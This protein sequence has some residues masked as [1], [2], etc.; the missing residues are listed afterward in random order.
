[1]KN[2]TLAVL[3]LLGALTSVAQ[4]THLS[5]EVVRTFEEPIG[6]TDLTGFSTFR[7][8]VHFESEDDFLSSIYGYGLDTEKP[9]AYSPDEED[10]AIVTDCECFNSEFGGLLGNR[11]SKRAMEMMPELVYNSYWTINLTNSDDKGFVAVATTITSGDSNEDPCNWRIDDGT[12][13]TLHDYPNGRAGADKKV[14]V[15]QVT[16]CSEVFTIELCVQT[17]IESSRDNIHY[18]CPDGPFEI[19]LKKE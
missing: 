14:L 4:P 5:Y 3:L 18:W 16:T 19:S 2:S 17:F 7:V 8:Y 11:V 12:I 6:S 13:F 9:F 1:M 10:V 15:A